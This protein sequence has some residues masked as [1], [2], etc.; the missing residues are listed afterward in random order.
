VVGTGGQHSLA[1]ALVGV[2]AIASVSIVYR[3]VDVVYTDFQSTILEV[4]TWRVECLLILAVVDGAC[5]GEA[6][7]LRGLLARRCVLDISVPIV[8]ARARGHDEVRI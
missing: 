4:A 3:R 1:Q 7:L 2:G 8:R 6:Q 5:V